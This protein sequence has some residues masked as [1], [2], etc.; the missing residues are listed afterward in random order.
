[1]LNRTR[2]EGAFAHATTGFPLNGRHVDID[3]ASCHDASAAGKL[4]GV[5]IAFE[6]GT[7]K[8]TFPKPRAATCATCHDDAHGQVFAAR[9]DSGACTA[10]HREAGWV[11]TTFDAV[12]HDRET[13]FPLEGAHVAVPC[14]SCHEKQGGAPPTFRLGKVTCGSCHAD[15]SPHGD[16]FETRSCDTCHTESSFT[17][18]HFDHAKTRFP[19]EGAHRSAPCAACHVP[20]QTRNGRRM[21]RYRPLGTECSDCHGGGA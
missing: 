9:P 10:C 21:V 12:R 18:E 3:C 1:V 5:H 15:S 20:E 14:Q 19:L 4:K 13:T 7:E 11:P 6:P 17:I 2:V 16:Q 8:H